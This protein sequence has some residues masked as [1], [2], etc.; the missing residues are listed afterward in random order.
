MRMFKFLKRYISVSCICLI[1]LF[2][3]TVCGRH[4]Y[5]PL[6]VTDLKCEYLRE[7]LGLDAEHP[8][9]SWLIGSGERGVQQSAYQVIAATDVTMLCKNRPDLWNSGKMASDQSI[10]VP[11]NGLSLKSGEKV[12]W[13]VRVWDQGDVASAWSD[14]ASWEMAMLAAEHWKASWIGAPEE[15]YS[16]GKER[17]A[18]YFRKTFKLDGPVNR[19]RAYITGLGYYELYVNGI[20]VG[21]HVLAPNQT[22]YDRRQEESWTEKKIGHMSSSV[23]YETHDS[24]PYL[25]KGENVIGVVV[26]NGW[27]LQSDRMDDVSLWYDTPRWSGQFLIEPAEGQALTILSDSTWKC[28]KSPI[29][30]NGLHTGE[31]Y[32]SRLETQGWSDQ[33]FDDRQWKRALVLRTPTGKMRVQTS[34]PDRITRTLVPVSIQKMKEGLYRYD[35]GEM[36]SGWSRITTSSPEGTT[37]SLRFIEEGGPSYGQ[38]DVYISNG[39]QEQKWQPRFTWHAFRYVDVSGPEMHFADSGLEALVVHTDVK[40]AGTFECSNPLFNRILDNYRRTQLGNIH[41]G[42]PSDCPHRERR[43]YTGDGQISAEAAIYN[44]DMAALYTKWLHDIADAQN[45]QTGYVPNTAPYQDGGGGTAWGSAL[46]IIPWYMYLYYGDVKVLTDHYEGMKKWITYLENQRHDDG[47]LY[48]QGLG[49]WVP[50]DRVVLPTEFV[51]TCYLYRCTDLM[52]KIASV[53][54]HKIDQAHFNQL[55]EDAIEAV[56]ENFFNNE[57]AEFDKGVQG[58]NA[59]AL[60][61]GMVKVRDRQ[62]VIA[63]LVSYYKNEGRLHFDTGILATPL[64]LS[65][66][67]Q[68]G[69]VDLA[70][71]IMSQRD[72][73]GY[74]HM[75]EEGATTLWETWLGEQSRSHPM[76]GSVC[77]WFYHYLGGI[78]P[79]ASAPGFKHSIIKPT[80]VYSLDFARTTYRS[81]YGTVETDW[82]FEDADFHLKITIPANTTAT[83][84]IPAID[85]ALVKMYGETSKQDVHIRYIG[86]KERHAVYEVSSGSFEFTSSGLKNQLPKPVLTTPVILPGDTTAHY[87]DSVKVTI[88]SD[89]TDAQIRYTTDSSDPESNSK[90]YQGQ[91]YV[92]Q[93]TVIKAR[94]FQENREPSFTKA[95]SIEFIDTTK[96]GTVYQ[97]F[98]A[99]NW[100]K[101]PDLKM[102]N[103]IKAGYAPQI[104]LEHIS[105]ENDQ[106]G[107]VFGGYLHIEQAGEYTFFLQSNDGSRLLIGNN[108]VVDNDGL[109]G[110]DEEKTGHLYLDAG[111]HP[112]RLEYFQAGGGMFLKVCLSS[113]IMSKK[114]VPASMLY[115]KLPIEN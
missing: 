82:S 24:G 26:G 115:R 31:I 29:T 97:Y 49:E 30:Y 106:F 76:F 62:R 21:D 74:G 48:N 70:Y 114:E 41:G 58:A 52:S 20:K 18:L 11:Y 42:V 105:P 112:L 68:S 7:P 78:R 25:Q 64:L 102:L 96:N 22:N 94:S 63:N 72:F 107:L 87:G 33:N 109:H 15:I 65:A 75:I 90:I 19:A 86:F 12:Y 32:D 3:L 59:F 83:V 56:Y 71:T 51:N 46:V 44:F 89:P 93:N 108:L 28:S 38:Q 16:M 99:G 10:H 91:L 14:V 37:I 80:P 17:P 54:G 36:I 43:G 53:L 104:N 81:P 67:S 55:S 39:R 92:D 85:P 113:L 27:Y 45:S 101:L 88:K 8:R 40:D 5:E 110:A 69:N 9:L 57:K 98:A 2:I 61:F 84:Y 47:L 79:D 95:V 111:F 13:K 6:T 50:P 100:A 34:P 1:S 4:K 35:F 23:L 103:P 73:P 66:L 77:A 60:A